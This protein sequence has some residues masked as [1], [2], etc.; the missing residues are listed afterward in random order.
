MLWVMHNK[1]IKKNKS[2]TAKLQNLGFQEAGLYEEK[3]I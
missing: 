3:T 2:T 1:L